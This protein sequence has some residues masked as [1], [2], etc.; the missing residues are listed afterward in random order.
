MALGAALA[1]PAG[2]PAATV[3]GFNA[4]PTTGCGQGYSWIQ[5]ASASSSYSVPAGGAIMTSVTVH[6]NANVGS[7]L[8]FKV[9]RVDPTDSAT[10]R[11]VAED[12]FRQLTP[13]VPNTF[14]THLAVAPG[15]VIGGAAVTGTGWG[16]AVSTAVTGDV[17]RYFPGDPAVGAPVA[18][19]SLPGYK[20]A[21]E[22]TV[23]ADADHDGRADDSEDAD[24][25]NDN[26]LDSIDNCPSAANTTQVDRDRDNVGDVCD[27]TPFRTTGACRNLLN[28]TNAGQTLTGTPFGDLLLG[29]GGND[30]LRGLG[31]SDCLEG[32]AGNDTLVGG[33]GNDKL[34]GDRGRNR[35]D[36]GA[37]SDFVHAVNGVRETIKCGPGNDTA[38][39]DRVDV[40]RGCEHVRR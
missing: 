20:L 4:T 32:G 35:Y 1:V 13:N 27:S 18:T 16:C 36:A 33:A 3:I 30:L 24:D 10:F 8:K 34:Y 17:L 25:D 15:D 21:M 5:A 28:G 26:V 23:E 6:A 22:A 12:V 11:T 31:G 19:L 9:W 40:T 38:L 39:V 14:T 7:N 29:N 2:A 37:G